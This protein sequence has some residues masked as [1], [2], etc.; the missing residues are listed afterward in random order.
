MHKVD[1]D[2]SGVVTV[3]EFGS[4]CSALRKHVGGSPP[5]VLSKPSRVLAALGEVGK[6]AMSHGSIDIAEVAAQFQVF[7]A[8]SLP[9]D[10][11]SAF[12]PKP[13]S[14]VERLCDWIGQ[15]PSSLCGPRVR[16][17]GEEKPLMNVHPHPTG[18]I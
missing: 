9:A 4:C 16:G 13:P 17:G 2:A 10:K 1:D 11:S 7:S 5:S 8:R 6:K 3:Q 14:C 12:S 15:G 18:Q